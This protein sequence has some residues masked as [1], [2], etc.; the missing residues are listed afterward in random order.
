MSFVDDVIDKYRDLERRLRHIERLDVNPPLSSVAAYSGTPAANE[1]A[2]WTGA[3]TV[4]GGRTFYVNSGGSVGIGTA[5]PTGALLHAVAP[6]RSSARESV[7]K[8]MVADNGAGGLLVY[9]DTAT[10]AAFTGAFGGYN[11]NSTRSPLAVTGFLN[12]TA[13]DTGVVPIVKF[14]A[15][16]TDDS[17]DPP[18]GTYSDVGTRLM[19]GWVNNATLVHAILASGASV[20]GGLTSAGA[21][22]LGVKAGTSSNDAA[23]GGV[24]YETRTQTGNVGSGEDDLASYSVPANTLS[25]DGMAIEFEAFGTTSSSGNTIHLRARFGTS[26]TNLLIDLLTDASSRDWRIWGRI[27]R[28]GAATQK[29]VTSILTDSLLDN[30]VVTGLDQTLSGAVTLKIT[31]EGTSSNDIVLE[32]FVVRWSDSNT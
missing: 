10:N 29:S 32:E 25:A 18:N 31:G 9:N 28:T 21:T 27:V 1:V 11:A 12:G 20:A 19:F 13:L 22:W 30:D 17:S 26:G 16:V 7:A 6:A 24:L 23:V 14:M 5:T 4:A 2:Y 15:V 8:F 3:G